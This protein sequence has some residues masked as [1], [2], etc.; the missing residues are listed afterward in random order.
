MMDVSIKLFVR[1]GCL[2]RVCKCYVFI[3]GNVVVEWSNSEDCNKINE[4]NLVEF[5]DNGFGLS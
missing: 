2:C 5:E 4:R 1:M 3:F